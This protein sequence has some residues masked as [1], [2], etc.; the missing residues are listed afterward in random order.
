MTPREEVRRRA[1]E[2]AATAARLRAMDSE[3]IVD[4]I[5]RA[6]S[7]LA[8]PENELGAEARAILPSS[9]GLGAAMV[10]WALRTS[11]APAT[12][13]NLGRLAK[14]IDGP[15]GTLPAHAR[16]AAIVLA[17]NVFTA[18]FRGVVLPLL[19][20]IPVVAKASSRDDVFPRLFSRALR[21]AAEEV[22]ESLDTLTFEGGAVELEDALFGQADVVAAYGSDTTLAEIRGRLPATTAFVPH[23]HG[24]GAIWV[25]ESAL[26][27]EGRAAE[28]ARKI[29]LDV[30]A[31]DQRG[32][33]SPHAVWVERGGAV[34]AVELAR[35]V[36]VALGR[37]AVELPRGPLSMPLGAQQVQWRGVAAARGELFEGDG[38]AVSFEGNGPLRLSPGHRN[39]SV[40]ECASADEL[41]QRLVPLGVH[42]KALGVAADRDAR[43]ALA[44]ALP[45]P[46]APRVSDVGDMQTPPLDSL[47]DGLSPWTG[48]VR[49]VQVD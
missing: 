46:L 3:R 5:A 27:D 8:D 16:L 10:D 22:G 1:S 31:Y 48:L 36:S 17:G 45:A 37:L 21:F 43:R 42:L 18:S 49:Y 32:C 44:R 6:A 28:V 13:E 15:K 41:H 47:A 30:A 23:G 29:A 40:L 38:W 34:P 20:G 33:L 11:L 19:A 25:P 14:S 4:A 7:S 35:L 39:V 26:T 9:T 24:L 2:V 12:E